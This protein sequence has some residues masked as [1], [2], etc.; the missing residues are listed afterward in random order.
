MSTYAKAQSAPCPSRAVQR[1]RNF[2]LQQGFPEPSTESRDR[3]YSAILFQPRLL[4]LAFVVGSILQLPT[5]FFVLGVILWL[6]VVAPRLNPFNAMYNRA[7][8]PF[9]GITLTA[10]PAPRRFSQFLGGS[11]CLAIAT[12]LTLGLH[13]TAFVLEGLLMAGTVT[14]L[15]GFCVGTFVFHLLRGH[16]GF[17][18]RT[19]PWAAN[20]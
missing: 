20:G 17:A 15:A 4:G 9:T 2:I 10:S 19:L 13:T 1:R 7:V 5:L 14:M 8:A 3:Q 12:S 6:C 16:A 11:F 18:M